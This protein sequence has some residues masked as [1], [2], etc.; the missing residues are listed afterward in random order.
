MAIPASSTTAYCELNSSLRARITDPAGD[1]SKAVF[2]VVRALIARDLDDVTIEHVIQAHPNGV[3]AKYV[4]R[5]DLAKEIARIRSK[6]SEPATSAADPL[7][8]LIETSAV[9]FQRQVRPRPSLRY[10]R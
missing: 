3:G 10:R 2:H 5:S 7:S 8:A 4:G 9:R 6:A 1:R